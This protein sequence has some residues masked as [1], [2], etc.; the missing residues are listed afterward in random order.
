MLRSSAPNKSAQSPKRINISVSDFASL[1]DQLELSG[2]KASIGDHRKDTDFN[3]SRKHLTP[4][5]STMAFDFA[6]HR[7]QGFGNDSETKSLAVALILNFMM[8]RLNAN[9]AV[10]THSTL[11]MVLFVDEA[12][13]LL[14]KEGKRLAQFPCAPGGRGIPGM[15]SVAGRRCIPHAW[16]HAT[17]SPT[18]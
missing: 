18:R 1:A 8:K 17:I 6:G 10:A 13:L 7:F 15:A 14:P 2:A 4:L 16:K 3:S 9:L 12:H 11:K 5:I